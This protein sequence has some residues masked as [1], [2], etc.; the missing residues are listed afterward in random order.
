MLVLASAHDALVDPYCSRRLA[1]AWALPIAEHPTAGHDLPLD[2]GA[3]V[4]RQVERW[5]CTSRA[6]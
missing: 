5:V 3:W 2:D 6:L 4:V 1:Q